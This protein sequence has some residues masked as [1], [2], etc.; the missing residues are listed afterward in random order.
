MYFFLMDYA[1]AAKYVMKPE[2]SLFLDG[3]I[4]LMLASL[5]HA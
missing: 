1:S 3:E 5:P 4:A 2:R